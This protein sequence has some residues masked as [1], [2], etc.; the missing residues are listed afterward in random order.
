M[1]K[2]IYSMSG[3]KTRQ[4]L[5]V[6]NFGVYFTDFGKLLTE[7]DKFYAVLLDFMSGAHPGIFKERGFDKINIKQT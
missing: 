4:V 2:V 1:F 7:F 3:I 5:S 6:N